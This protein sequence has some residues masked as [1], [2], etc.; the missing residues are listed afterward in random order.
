MVGLQAGL[1]IVVVLEMRLIVVGVVVL[2]IQSIWSYHAIDIQEDHKLVFQVMSIG[3]NRLQAAMLDVKLVSS[4]ELFCDLQILGI[5]QN[6]NRN[7]G[8]FD[9][10]TLLYN[11]IFGA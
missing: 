9:L 7:L 3:M 6:S 11:S 1:D 4:M 10:T 5:V 8:I 2:G